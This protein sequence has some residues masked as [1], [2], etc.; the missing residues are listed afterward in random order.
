MYVKEKVT[1]LRI[2][3]ARV[4]HVLNRQKFAS[5]AAEQL[6]TTGPHAFEV[7]GGS[8]RWQI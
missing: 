1:F 6:V 5:H 7:E 8:E 2:L 3:P 4:L